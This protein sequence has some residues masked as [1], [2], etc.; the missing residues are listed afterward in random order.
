MEREWKAA[1]WSQFGAAIDMLERAVRACPDDLWRGQGDAP[2][3]WSIVQHALLWLDLYLAGSVEGFAPPPP[4]GL[5]EL[6]PSGR[7]PERAYS[8]DELVAYLEHGRERCR[9]AIEAL[10]D[11]RAAQ[12]CR[13]GWGEVSYAELLI[14]NLHHVQ[15][16]AGELSSLIGQALGSGPGWVARTKTPLRAE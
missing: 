2:G 15:D 3:A 4:F 14:Y 8:K 11:A 10:S 5:E 13:F 1:P 16:H 9:G 7:L 6:D 12:R